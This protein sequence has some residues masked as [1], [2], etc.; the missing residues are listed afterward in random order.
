MNI[1]G[2]WKV[3]ITLL[4]K[5]FCFTYALELTNGHFEFMQK[6]SLFIQ[7]LP[8][9]FALVIVGLCDEGEE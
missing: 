6:Q 2:K 3:I 9:I 1:S 4:C 5:I 7:I 8:F